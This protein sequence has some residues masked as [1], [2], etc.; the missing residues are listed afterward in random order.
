MERD[1]SAQRE[2]MEREAS[3]ER[4]A[5]GTP[6]QPAVRMVRDDEAIAAL[7]VDRE[8][9]MPSNELVDCR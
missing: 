5:L 8:L 2:R 6:P 9:G 3:A 4:L 1:A 7:V